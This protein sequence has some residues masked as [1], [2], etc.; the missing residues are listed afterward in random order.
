MCTYS[1]V[2][3]AWLHASMLLLLVPVQSR[4]CCL[5]VC[6]HAAAGQAVL[7]EIQA[8][9]A[10]PSREQSTAPTMMKVSGTLVE[11]SRDVVLAAFNLDGACR[12]VC[13]PLRQLTH[14]LTGLPHA[15]LLPAGDLDL[16]CGGYHCILR[17]C[18]LRLCGLWRH[19][20]LRWEQGRAGAAC[21]VRGR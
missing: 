14:M 5:A 20:Q 15:T 1:G 12:A 11:A 8:T 13:I 3:A 16:V 4:K 19:R 6:W 10:R 18:D 7:P 21:K 9:L 2:N 17:H